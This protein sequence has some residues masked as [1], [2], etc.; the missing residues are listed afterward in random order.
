[1]SLFSKPTPKAYLGIDI[2]GGGVKIAEL[3]NEKGRAKLI[4]YGFSERPATKTA[5]NLLDHAEETAARIRAIMTQA[6]MTTTRVVSGLPVAAVFSSVVVVPAGSGKTLAAAVE[7][8]AKKLIHLPLEEMILEHTV[9]PDV[10][11]GEQKP[12]YQRVLITAAP[13]SLVKKY[14]EIFKLAQ[15]E[16]V[17]LETEAFALIRSL[18]GRDMASVMIVDIGAVRTNMSVV[19][20]GIPFLNR[21]L[22][23]GGGALTKAIAEGS[24]IPVDQAENMKRDARAMSEIMPQM[25]VPKLLEPS[26]TALVNEIRYSMNLYAGQNTP[27]RPI[28]KIV[29]TGGTALFPRLAEAVAGQVGIKVY[30]GDPWARVVYPLDLRPELDQ[31]GPRFSVAIGLAMR[32]IS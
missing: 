23:I 6:G 7:V 8:Q 10:P 32:D 16:L 15:L 18:V 20:Q 5:E 29:L 3:A 28:E 9:M 12:G 1:M 13:K 2:G 30:V 26:M 22:N 31:I 24:G 4:N 25:G 19:Q 17:S 27:P 14:I 11:G 21:S